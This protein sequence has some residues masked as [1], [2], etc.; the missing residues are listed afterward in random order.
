ML[1]KK[2]PKKSR[3]MLLSKKFSHLFS[4]I[5]FRSANPHKGPGIEGELKPAPCPRG[6]CTSEGHTP[7]CFRK[8]GGK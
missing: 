8:F 1:G 5:H 7:N 2:A 6:I 4:K 3:S